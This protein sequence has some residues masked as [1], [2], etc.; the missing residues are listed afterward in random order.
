MKVLE[1]QCYLGWRISSRVDGDEDGLEWRTRGGM[2]F[3]CSADLE[4]EPH[5][6]RQEDS[7]SSLRTTVT[8]SSSSGHTSGQFVNPKY[9]RF[10]LPSMSLSVKVVPVCEVK[11]NGPP[12]FGRP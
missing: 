9:T 2:G 11:E 4:Y 5:V 12:T 8:L 3:S 7:P 6:R 10:H 1:V